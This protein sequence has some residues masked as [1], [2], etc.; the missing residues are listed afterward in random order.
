MMR[1]TLG[2]L[3]LVMAG[4][5]TCEPPTFVRKPDSTDP[6]NTNYLLDEDPGTVTIPELHARADVLMTHYWDYCQV[7]GVIWP[8]WRT[9]PT[10][11]SIGHACFWPRRLSWA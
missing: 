6:W 4:C 11:S 2:L 8:A 7:D 5:K 9:D 10:P 3:V 1:Y